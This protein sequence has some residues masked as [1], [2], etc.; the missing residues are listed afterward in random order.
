MLPYKVLYIINPDK[1]SGLI[2]LEFYPIQFYNK[3]ETNQKQNL[4]NGVVKYTHNKDRKAGHYGKQ[5]I[6][7][8][9]LSNKE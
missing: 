7:L 6:H 1:N 4:K 5:K 9:L 8:Q 3:T 2:F